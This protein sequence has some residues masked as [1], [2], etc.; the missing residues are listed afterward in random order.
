MAQAFLVFVIEKILRQGIECSNRFNSWRRI[1][2]LLVVHSGVEG[3]PRSSQKWPTV[4]TTMWTV[5]F[6]GEEA[7]FC[8]VWCPVELLIELHVLQQR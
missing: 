2:H 7:S 8:L 1:L 4:A 3:L 5:C 6:D